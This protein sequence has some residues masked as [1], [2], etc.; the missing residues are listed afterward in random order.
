[1]KAFINGRTVFGTPFQVLPSI[2][3][4][5]MVSICTLNIAHLI[6]Q[7]PWR[8]IPLSMFHRSTSLT[9]KFSLKVRWLPT[10]AAAESVARWATSWKTARCVRSELSPEKGMNS[11]TRKWQ[12]RCC[13]SRSRPRRDSE[14]RLENQQ[15][16]M[17]GDESR[18]VFRKRSEHRRKRDP[19][20]Q[21]CCFL[22][23]SAAH[24]KKDCQ[25]YNNTAGYK[26]IYPFRNKKQHP[27]LIQKMLSQIAETAQAIKFSLEFGCCVRSFC[28][29][30]LL[31]YFKRFWLS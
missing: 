4:S 24:I 16:N 1:M 11:S 12:T 13:V 31:F 29:I 26:G 17:D 7:K 8:W 19:L 3:P 25:L 5:H 10:I 23:G 20:E 18:D 28:N 6:Q 14:K 9:L 30:S 22:C 27:N 2:Y 15:E 21:R